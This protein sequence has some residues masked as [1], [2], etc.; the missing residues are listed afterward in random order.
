MI[1]ADR[2]E[3][4][5]KQQIALFLG[6]V[7]A[8]EGEMQLSS[9]KMKVHYR[10]RQEGAKQ[11]DRIR[12]I[13]A[14][15]NVTLRQ[16]E[17]IGRAAKAKYHVGKRFLVLEGDKKR[18]AVVQRNKDRLEGQRIH[19]MMDDQRRIQKVTV[20]GGQSGRVS[21]VITPEGDM[22]PVPGKKP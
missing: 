19:L 6:N 3:M 1:S 14:E 13:L 21:A 15:G 11:T 2:L 17:H 10:P 5:E 22:Q 7:Q 16:G 18:A 4:N 9:D 20:Q 12:E 8:E